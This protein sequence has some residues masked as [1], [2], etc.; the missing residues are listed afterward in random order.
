MREKPS[1]TKSFVRQ[2]LLKRA[3]FQAIREYALDPSS[4]GNLALIVVPLLPSF[5]FEFDMKHNLNNF[6]I[7]KNIH[8]IIYIHVPKTGG[9]TINHTLHKI[10]SNNYD[11]KQCHSHHS[12]KDFRRPKNE[13]NIN[14]NG[15]CLHNNNPFVVYIISIRNPIK[16][17]ISAFYHN[18]LHVDKEKHNKLGIKCI[19]TFLDKLFINNDI[20]EE[21]EERFIVGHLKFGFDEYLSSFLKNKH[22]SNI[23]VL[24]TDDLDR[25]L[26]RKLHIDNNLI[27]RGQEHSFIPKNQNIALDEKHIYN[28]K[29]YLKKEYSILEKLKK[30]NLLTEDE[31]S[32]IKN[33]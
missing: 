16:R 8:D 1:A 21:I 3:H 17:F 22:Y 29:N 9:G 2:K 18:F 12:S 27:Y 32:K 24:L 19:N 13:E 14:I 25:E 30:L 5:N 23:I 11:Y 26:N 31:Y 28:L 10:K 6:D 4:K 20:S 33:Y 7:T 15:E